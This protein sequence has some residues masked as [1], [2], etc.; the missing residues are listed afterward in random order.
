VTPASIPMLICLLSMIIFPSHLMLYNTTISYNVA[1]VKIDC[2]HVKKYQIQQS[3][4]K[5]LY[6]TENHLNPV[7][8]SQS[9]FLILTLIL[10]RV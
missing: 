2:W 10:S 9:I 7:Q 4:P 3:I 5:P 8:N 6:I 1:N